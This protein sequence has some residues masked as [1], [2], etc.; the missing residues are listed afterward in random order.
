VDVSADGNYLFAAERFAGVRT[1]RILRFDLPGAAGPGPDYSAVHFDVDEWMTGAYDVA[2]AADGTVLFTTERFQGGVGPLRQFDAA[3]GVLAFRPPDDAVNPNALLSRSANF[4]TVLVS[5]RDAA[6]QAYLRVYRAGR[7][8]APLPRNVSGQV[9]A[10]TQTA[11]S[12]DGSRFVVR[13]S[14]TVVTDASFNPIKTLPGIDGGFAFDPL[15]PLFYGVNTAARQ[16]VAYDTAG[17]RELYRIP[18]GLALPSMSPM[19]SGAMAVSDDGDWLFLTVAGQ[20]VRVFALPDR[21]APGVAA[22]QIFYNGSAFDR[23]DSA[24]NAF[25]DDAVATDKQPLLP[26]RPVTAANIS[27]YTKGLNGLMIDLV[28]VDA[29]ANPTA[30]DFSFQA[31]SGGN[32]ATWPNAPAPKV[33]SVRRGAGA[34]GSAPVVVTWPDAPRRNTRLRL[35]D[36]AT[37]LTGLTANDVF[38]FG[39][40]VGDTGGTTSPPAVDADDILR[41]R[42]AISTGPVDLYSAADHNRDGRVNVLDVLAARGN[43]STTA[44]L[45]LAVLPLP[46]PI[47]AAGRMPTRRAPTRA[48]GL[49]RE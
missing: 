43:L 22:R 36:N 7:G 21:P 14:S 8:L 28:G 11:V 39:N 19:Q 5:D 13:R 18:V 24:V 31:G 17:W 37:P 3:T 47:V 46:D 32:P 34:G 48:T 38:Y 45:P 9:N 6:Q 16:I 27:S 10:L 23:R 35:T 30:V 1:S 41:T 4:S 12:P 42:A 44:A 2:A 40:L 25:D 26:G 49:L 33:V 29:A 20:G 15:Q